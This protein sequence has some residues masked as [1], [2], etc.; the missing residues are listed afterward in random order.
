MFK[1]INDLKKAKALQ[2]MMAAERITKEKD[3]V[4]ISVNGQ[5]QI[6]NIQLNSRLELKHQ[7]ELIKDLTN[8]A[9]RDLQKT[10]AVKLFQK[11]IH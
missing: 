1:K 4:V 3:G 7:E 11:S 8:E 5:M 6:E 9:L 10:L 2:K